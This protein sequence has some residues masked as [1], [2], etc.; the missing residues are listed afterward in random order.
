MYELRNYA[1]VIVAQL[2][3]RLIPESGICKCEKCRLDVIA[4][5]LNRLPARYVVSIKGALLAESELLAMQKSTDYLSAVLTAIRQ[6]ES[7]P[8]HTT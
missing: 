3:D 5:A 7:M 2:A 6:V 1:E 8:R 4:L